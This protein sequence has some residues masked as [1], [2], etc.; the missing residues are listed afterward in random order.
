MIETQIVITHTNWQTMDTKSISMSVRKLQNRIV[1]A[2]KAGRIRMVKK[3]QKLLVKSFNARLLAVKRVSENKGKKTAG[4]DGK[5]L[6]TNRK[7]DRCV[8]ELKIDLSTYK[9]QPLKRIEIP[10]KKW[11]DETTRNTYNV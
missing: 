1:N 6:D 8:E 10:K 4:V 5:L 7:K 3:L 9:S 2:K 11:K